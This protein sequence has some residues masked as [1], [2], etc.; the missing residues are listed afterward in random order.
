MS[1]QGE[2]EKPLL[3]KENVRERGIYQSLKF[4]GFLRK[5]ILNEVTFV[6][7]D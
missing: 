3:D 5:W 1:Y 4:C 7:F 2:K 6:E